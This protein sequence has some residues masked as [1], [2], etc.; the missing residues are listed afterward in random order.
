MLDLIFWGIILFS[1]Y[2]CRG[3]IYGFFDVVI[4]ILLVVLRIFFVVYRVVVA[5]VML[6]I[7]GSAVITLIYTLHTNPQTITSFIAQI[8]GALWLLFAF[9]MIWLFVQIRIR[10]SMTPSERFESDWKEERELRKLDE[11]RRRKRGL[12]L[13]GNN[14]TFSERQE[15]HKLNRHWWL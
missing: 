3:I 9:F 11:Q 14:L 4:K 2:A 15:L 8:P 5:F 12:E 13:K 10:N 1:L 6:S 7:V